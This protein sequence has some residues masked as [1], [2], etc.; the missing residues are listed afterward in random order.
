M[1]A[2]AIPPSHQRRLRANLA[3]LA[4]THPE[5][6][7]QLQ[8]LE[9]PDNINP[10]TGRDGSDTYQI[11]HGGGT[12]SWFGQS[13]MPGISTAALIGSVETAGRNLILPTIGSGGEALLAAQQLPTHC[14][15]FIFEPEPINIKLALALHE[16]AE[17]L[18]RRRLVLLTGSDPVGALT[19]WFEANP[20]YEFPQHLLPVPLLPQTTLDQFRVAFETAGAQVTGKQWATAEQLS[21]HATDAVA[22]APPESPRTVV[23]SRDPRPEILTLAQSLQR[24]GREIGWDVE[25]AV[26]DR[27]DRCHT[28]ARVQVIQRQAPELILMLNCVPGPLARF[29]RDGQPLCSWLT[30]PEAVAAAQADGFDRCSAIFGGTADVVAALRAGGAP[31][32]RIHLLEA[33]TDTTVFRPIADHKRSRQPDGGQIA[34]LADAVDLRP[35]AAGI[36]LASQARLWTALCEDAASRVARW[37]DAQ[38]E[39]LLERGERKTGV[40]LAEQPLRDRFLI[41]IR[42]RLAPALL[43]RTTVEALIS[44]GLTV[45]LWGSGWDQPDGFPERHRGPLPDPPGRNEIYNAARVVVCP[46][47]DRA[48]VQTVLD[49]L[50]AGGCP[51]LR[52]PEISLRQIHPQL[53]DVLEHLPQAA[54]FDELTAL[55]ERLVHDAPARQAAVGATREAVLAAHTLIHRLG[56]IRDRLLDR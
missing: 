8:R 44:A 39:A 3:A 38:A 48:A 24:A 26:P 4:E 32:E 47:F 30:G 10:A 56:F 29:L 7:E 35:E 28:V 2:L 14:A 15:V 40:R 43:T 11:E 46:W 41:L 55:A 45:D 53:A 52:T 17:L 20:G 12:R 9:I 22:A 42:H 33:A 37:T 49:C 13:S 18:R 21:P 1:D 27:P 51:L 31:T 16:Y 25:V 23:L 19:A 6:T 34:V 50:A 54:T 5:L 36:N